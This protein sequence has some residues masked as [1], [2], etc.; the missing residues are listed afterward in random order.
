VIGIGDPISSE[1]F[2]TFWKMK[3][4]LWIMK[5]WIRW[6]EMAAWSVWALLMVMGVSLDVM[7]ELRMV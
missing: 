6:V 4:M 3:R 5:N 2:S 1:V 7:V